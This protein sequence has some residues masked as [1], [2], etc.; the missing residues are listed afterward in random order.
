MKP[1]QF[2]Q[3]KFRSALHDRGITIKY[4]PFLRDDTIV[5][6]LTKEPN[7]ESLAF[8]DPIDILALV[9]HNPSPYA[10][11]SFGLEENIDIMLEVC[12]QDVLD[13]GIV[14]HPG[15]KFKFNN[16][17]YELMAARRDK[18]VAEQHISYK[19]ACKYHTGRPEAGE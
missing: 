5:D 1:T 10:R 11:L 3:D 8:G 7:D 13:A 18:Q 14:F 6:K 12:T 9:N 15:D 16:T 19:L 17:Q 2:L 4:Y